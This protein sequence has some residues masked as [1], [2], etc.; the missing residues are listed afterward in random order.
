MMS[1]TMERRF[2]K[3]M[4][5]SSFSMLVTNRRTAIIIA[6]APICDAKITAV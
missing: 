5:V 1:R 3:N 6:L 4:G 2:T